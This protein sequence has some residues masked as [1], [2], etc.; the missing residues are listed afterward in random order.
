MS[1]SIFLLLMCLVLSMAVVAS[2]PSPY[3]GALGVMAVACF[4]C[5][6]LVEYGAVFLSLVLFLIYL[7]GMMVVFAYSSALAAEPYPETPGSRVALT[8]FWS[9]MICLVL[10]LAFTWSGGS[11]ELVILVQGGMEHEGPNEVYRVRAGHVFQENIGEG[12][13]E[14]EILVAPAP[15]ENDDYHP[16]MLEIHHMVNLDFV[17]EPAE[18]PVLAPAEVLVEVPVEPGVAP[19][20]GDPSGEV[21]KG[22]AAVALVCSV[23]DAPVVLDTS[24]ILSFLGAAMFFLL[25]GG[26]ILSFLW[27][28]ARMGVVSMSGFVKG[29]G[30][31][32]R[33][34]GGCL[35]GLVGGPSDVGGVGLM[36][37]DGGLMLIL[38]GGA[39]LLALFVVFEVCQGMTRGALKAV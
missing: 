20:G 5:G 21:G 29:K 23:N 2:N 6:V 12:D 9:Y 22:L 31:F 19:S 17:E 34:G 4:G 35:V 3:F 32:F 1:I 25:L 14:D 26:C 7:G 13:D 36:Y 28:H 30:S 10:V 39:L 38:C 33:L 8:Y 18:G 11:D 16:P 27:Y 15:E 37:S 24:V